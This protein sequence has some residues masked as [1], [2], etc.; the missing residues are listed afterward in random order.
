MEILKTHQL[1][2]LYFQVRDLQR[3]MPVA[4]VAFC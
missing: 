2:Q 1:D 4:V 3:L